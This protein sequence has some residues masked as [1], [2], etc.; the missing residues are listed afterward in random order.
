MHEKNTFAI[1][2]TATSRTFKGQGDDQRFQVP[3]WI[4]AVAISLIVQFLGAAYVTGQMS[5]KIDGL[6]SRVGRIESQLDRILE[7][8]H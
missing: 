5:E 8:P 7:I 2:E 4:W 1:E 3:P 6:A